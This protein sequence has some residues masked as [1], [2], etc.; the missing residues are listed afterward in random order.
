MLFPCLGQPPFIVVVVV[1]V[2]AVVVVVVVFVFHSH[3]ITVTNTNPEKMKTP[4]KAACNISSHNHAF[5]LDTPVRDTN[6][7]IAIG[8]QNGHD[9][10]WSRR[11]G[12]DVG[13]RRPANNQP[14]KQ[15]PCVCIRACTQS[16]TRPGPANQ[17]YAVGAGWQ[18]AHVA[19]MHTMNQCK[20]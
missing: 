8:H 20:Q 2:V 13:V 18:E 17:P 7:A 6:Y 9:K 11:P 1:V 14:F 16:V 10:V 3:N 4:N 15:G 19:T 12:N 5:N